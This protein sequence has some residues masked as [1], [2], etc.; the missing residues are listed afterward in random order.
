MDV[1]G[2]DNRGCCMIGLVLKKKHDNDRVEQ[3]AVC[4]LKRDVS[5]GWCTMR[6]ISVDVQFTI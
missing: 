1:A 4:D 6:C 5:Y 3:K 2:K